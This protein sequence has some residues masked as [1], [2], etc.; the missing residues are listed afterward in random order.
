MKTVQIASI[1]DRERM[2]KKT[3]LSLINQVDK[4]RVMLNGYPYIPDWLDGLAG[5]YKIEYYQLDNSLGDAAK[6]YPGYSDGY[7]FT[8]DDD[9]IYPPDYIETTVDAI[10][11]NNC[12]ISLHGRVMRPRP[13]RDSYKDKKKW[14]HCLETVTGYHF[15]D[16]AGTGVMGF[17]TKYFIP[18]ITKMIY[19]NMADIWVAKQAAEQNKTLMVMPHRQ[20]WLEYQNPSNTIWDN[21]ASNVKLQTAVYNTILPLKV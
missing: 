3:I 2:L 13:I 7:V 11:K 8:C 15:V 16:I 21:R 4:I 20:G 18:T 6:F 10:D 14:Y 19:P 9:L 17:H 1:P 5:S 12:I